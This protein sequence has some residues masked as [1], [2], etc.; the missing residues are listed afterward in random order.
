MQ[1]LSVKYATN[2][3]V[4]TFSQPK[5]FIAHTPSNITQTLNL[6]INHYQ[7]CSSNPNSPNSLK[8]HKIQ[9]ELGVAQVEF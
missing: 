5:N 2:L 8:T 3:K 1:R 4:K 9:E 7:F 6:L